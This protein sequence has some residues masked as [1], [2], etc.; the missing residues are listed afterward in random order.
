[1]NVI[2]AN[3]CVDK[4]VLNSLR[5]EC[6]KEVKKTNGIFTFDEADN[7]QKGL[8][9]IETEKEIITMRW[10][11]IR[12]EVKE[13]PNLVLFFLNQKESADGKML[14]SIEDNAQALKKLSY[15]SVVVESGENDL[16]DSLYCLMKQNRKASAEKLSA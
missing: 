2:A 5:S 8:W 11:T 14:K 6:V 12:I 4:Q 9:L 10:L 3:Q 13:K 1:M 7:W 16:A 15:L